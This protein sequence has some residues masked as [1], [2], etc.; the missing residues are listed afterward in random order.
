MVNNEKE[1]TVAYDILNTLIFRP[2]LT[3]P[4][5]GDEIWVVPHPF[6]VVDISLVFIRE[7]K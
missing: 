6:L 5:T 1:D 2:D 3:L 4:L 7:L